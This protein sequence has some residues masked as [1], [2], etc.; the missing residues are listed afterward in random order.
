MMVRMV[1]RARRIRMSAVG[2]QL[3]RCMA[4][5]VL[6]LPS[7]TLRCV[8]SQLVRHCSGDCAARMPFKPGINPFWLEA[9]R[10]TAS[11]AGV[12]DLGTFAG[13]VDRVA[14]DTCVLGR[15]A[16]RHPRLHRRTSMLLTSPRASMKSA[17]KRVDAP[18]ALET[19]ARPDVEARMAAYH[20][21]QDYEGRA[22]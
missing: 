2:P 11:N 9:D 16:D 8:S 18:G 19:P 14:T 1:R 17:V 10:P 22:P 7:V 13:R 12:F 20:R 4:P 5:L 3:P 15:F 21:H 6:V